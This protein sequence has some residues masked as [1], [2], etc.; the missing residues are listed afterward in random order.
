M[1][2][3]RQ[4]VEV[5]ILHNY[6]I[7]TS[8]TFFNDCSSS[9]VSHTVKKLPAV[10][11]PYGTLSFPTST[12][13]SLNPAVARR[14]LSLWIRY[15][16]GVSDV[17]YDL[18]LPMHRMLHRAEKSANIT[19]SNILVTVEPKRKR[20]MVARRSPDS[21]YRTKTP[22][23]VGETILWDN[24]FSISLLSRRAGG[25]SNNNPEGAPV[26]YV[27]HFVERDWPLMSKGVVRHK[28]PVT[29]RGGLPVVVDEQNKIVLI[30]H[31]RVASR[32]AN[33]VAV[34]RFRPAR[35]IDDLLQYSHYH[36]C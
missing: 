16:G 7:A 21:R 8:F 19:G 6:N 3:I 18:V 22:I 33:I 23:R 20:V 30:P 13:R 27:R 24:R 31:F 28:A 12:Y 36:E 5:R 17:R 2:C 10:D 35:T 32:E 11:V 15:I 9:S 34:V 26:F 25:G 4:I 29:V 14:A 1:S